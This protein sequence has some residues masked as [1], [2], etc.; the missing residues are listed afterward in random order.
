M[1]REFPVST[2]EEFQHNLRQACAA[3]NSLSRIHGFT[4]EQCLLGQ[5]RALPGSIVSDKGTGS[6]ALAESET[7]GQWFKESLRR[8]EAARRAF[9]QADNDSTFQRALLRRNRTG[10]VEFESGDWV[11]YS[12]GVKTKPTLGANVVA[13]MGQHR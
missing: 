9:V 6:H 8:R 1:D 4:P 7:E 5:A 12:I 2:D 13:G 10:T 11:L 3:K